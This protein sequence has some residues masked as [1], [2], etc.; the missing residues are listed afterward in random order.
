[1]LSSAVA[2]AIVP[3]VY[4][5]VALTHGVTTP[6]D[7]MATVLFAPLATAT[8]AAVTY[9]R[10]SDDRGASWTFAVSFVGGVL[11]ARGMHLV[12]GGTEGIT[13]LL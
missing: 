4:V 12:V 10:M 3:V 1:V 7:G 9:R 5:A 8:V 6:V 13:A 11:L 2:I